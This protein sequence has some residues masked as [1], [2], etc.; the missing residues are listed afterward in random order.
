[1][2][3]LDYLRKKPGERRGEASARYLCIVRNCDQPAVAHFDPPLAGSH[4]A[5]KGRADDCFCHL[6]FWLTVIN[7]QQ[8]KVQF[9]PRSLKKLICS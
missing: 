5:A 7:I 4:L 3:H 9:D 8:N 2:I 1:M 6:Q